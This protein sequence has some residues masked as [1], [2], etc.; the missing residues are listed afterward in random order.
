MIVISVIVLLANAWLLCG[1]MFPAIPKF[2]RP[3]GSTSLF[4]LLLVFTVVA[5]WS[6]HLPA[7][8]TEPLQNILENFAWVFG[9]WANVLLVIAIAV[10]W[11]FPTIPV[12]IIMVVTGILICE[13]LIFLL[14]CDISIKSDKRSWHF[15]KQFFHMLLVVFLCFSVVLFFPMSGFSYIFTPNARASLQQESAIADDGISNKLLAASILSYAVPRQWDNASSS[16]EY[17]TQI[18]KKEYSVKG[19]VSTIVAYAPNADTQPSGNSALRNW[20]TVCIFHERVKTSDGT[21]DSGS[22]AYFSAQI[23]VNENTEEAILVYTGTN[24]TPT[25]LW[26]DGVALGFTGT[27]SALVNAEGTA[28]YLVDSVGG[29]TPIKSL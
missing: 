25:L 28:Q 12:T 24:D 18:D 2:P 20:K 4:F 22:G 16:G 29:S 5:I 23:I 3:L 9:Y 8:Q 15:T 19:G 10:A 1:W 17:P 26:E 6:F 13:K 27:S 7:H 21:A 11:L 14:V